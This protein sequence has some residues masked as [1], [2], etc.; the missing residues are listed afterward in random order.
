MNFLHRYRVLLL[1]IS[2]ALTFL[3]YQ[4]GVYGDYVFDDMA[5]ITQNPSLEM[6]SWDAQSL[7]E[8][9]MSSYSGML[10]RPIS[11]A[12]FAI[13]AT[14]TG[15]KNPLYFKVTNILIHLVNGALV[16]WLS[17]LILR[18]FNQQNSHRI[19]EAD[20]SVIQL[21]VT[22]MWLLHPLNLTSVLYIVQRMTSL[23]AMFSFAAVGMYIAGRMRLNRQDWR[24]WLLVL[25]GLM[26]AGTLA[27][28]SK[29]NGV[30]VPLLMLVAEFV[31]FRF[32]GMNKRDRTLLRLLFALTVAAPTVLFAIGTILN[33]PRLYASYAVRDF[34]MSERL[35]TQARVLWFYLEMILAPTISRLGLYHDDF[36]VSRSLWGPLTTAPAVLGIMAMFAVGILARRKMPVV[37]FGILWFLGAHALESTTLPLEMVHEHRNYLAILGPLLMISY[38]LCYVGSSPDTRRLRYLATILLLGLFGT[39]TA[40][41]SEQWGNSVIFAATEAANHPKSERAN[42]QLGRTYFLLYEDSQDPGFIKGADEAFQKAR[43]LSTGGVIPVISL[44]QLRSRAGQPVGRELIDDLEARLGTK[45]LLPSV[46][47]GMRALVDCQMFA[48]CKLSESDVLRVFE[49]AFRNPL[50]TLP[51]LSSLRLFLAQYQVDTL[52]DIPA[53]IQLIQDGLK[54]DPGHGDLQLNMARLY[55]LVLQFDLAEQHLQQARILDTLGH[56]RIEIDEEAARLRRDSAAAFKTGIELKAGK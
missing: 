13:N 39:L 23:A 9:S 20:L 45:P 16:F 40:M 56:H 5:N 17:G 19:A 12:S 49:A 18:Q 43:A 31:L 24:G 50:A 55:R 44:I 47:S 2:L 33:S 27:A 6:K 3:A 28:L 25:G 35:L 21:A 42:Q 54:A 36:V 22:A 41:R 38:Y 48:Y 4:P 11:M 53:G 32:E 29:E 10:K 7:Y 51:V 15:L 30:L 14:A 1:V 8:A 46:I 26:G 52:G 34:D 37:S